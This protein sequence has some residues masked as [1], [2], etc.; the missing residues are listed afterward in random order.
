[1]ELLCYEICYSLFKGVNIESNFHLLWNV[2]VV[3][4]LTG[5]FQPGLVHTLNLRC[6]TLATEQH[7]KVSTNYCQNCFVI[8]F[9]YL[10][11]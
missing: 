11:V 8:L 5:T 10:I 3:P 6:R 4:L 9:H 2:W 1:M 7:S